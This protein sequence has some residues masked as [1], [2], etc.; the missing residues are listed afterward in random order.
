MTARDV[1]LV[2]TGGG[3]RA[4]Y[5]AGVLEG[6]AE[7][8]RETT[9]QRQPLEGSPFNVVAGISAG[10]ING[11]YLATRSS[12]FGAATQELGMLWRDLR[13]ELVLRTD[14]RSLGVLGS[15]WVRDLSLGGMLGRTRSTHL[16][17]TAP[18]QE[19]LLERMHFDQIQA[20]LDAGFLRGVAVSATNYHTGTAITFYEGLDELEPWARSGRL[21]QAARLNLSHVLASS[22]IPL[23]FQP[24]R[25]GEAYYG[26]GGIRLGN[27]L[28]PAIHLGARRL[29]AIGIRYQRPAA[30][31]R[32]LNHVDLPLREITL[33]DIAGVMLNA[34]F[35]DSLDSD[36][37][38][39]ERINEALA[40]MTPEVAKRQRVKS[41]PLLHILP[42]RDLGTLASTE[43]HKLPRMLRYLLRGIGASDLQGWDFLS[44]MAFDR[45]YTE[46]LLEL[47]YLDARS[48]R[49]D[50]LSFFGDE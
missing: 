47:G 41:I 4:A 21:G 27:P 10:A 18:L 23:L 35:M 40:A 15:R 20:N 43:F 42:S 37:E 28:S 11:V 7:I 14:L 19:F 2:L 31:T 17:N 45:A 6:I 49:D 38:R 26:D 25:I 24:V 5:Q 22:A 34:A 36:I 13:P 16:L 50:L 48:R 9:V 39:L 8:L 30:Q 46:R 3:A 32:A 44:Y 29:L 33:A 12:Q 1:G